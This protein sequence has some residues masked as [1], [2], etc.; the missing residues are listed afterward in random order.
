MRAKASFIL[1]LLI[2]SASAESA[3]IGRI[4]SDFMLIG[5]SGSG[6]DSI[7]LEGVFQN[8]STHLDF[9]GRLAVLG[10]T[11]NGSG[12]DVPAYVV[13]IT[14]T[15]LEVVCLRQEGCNGPWMGFEVRLEDLVG[16]P[17]QFSIANSLDGFVSQGEQ[18]TFALQV[19]QSVTDYESVGDPLISGQY[20]DPVAVWL[21]HSIAFLPTEEL[22]DFDPYE[23]GF[24]RT[25]SNIVTRVHDSPVGSLAVRFDSFQASSMIF[26]QTLSLPGS[27][28]VTLDFSPVPEP[29][30]WSL[31]LPGLASIL[32][33]RRR[34]GR[35]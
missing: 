2:S 30:T 18:P 19:Q 34:M 10:V 5:R 35:R 20:F 12:Y 23:G 25:G 29:E 16:F 6:S 21:A 33:L 26:G 17:S 4:E 15:E 27:Y 8:I 14:V 32:L 9:T 22:F 1:T 3:M 31:L 28:T 11:P 13:Q 24:S 7:L